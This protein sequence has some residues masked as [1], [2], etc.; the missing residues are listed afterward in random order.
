MRYIF[1]RLKQTTFGKKYLTD[2]ALISFLKRV[3]HVLE[4]VRN[5]IRSKLPIKEHYDKLLSLFEGYLTQEPEIAVLDGGTVDVIVPIYNGY[6]YLLRLFEDLPKTA[7]SCRYI[8]VDDKSPDA[9]VQELEQAFV[10]QYPGSV[11]LQN[12]QNLG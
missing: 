6:E 9:R 11:L 12:S 1:E 2:G 4:R 3:K 5:K 10:K 8:L 7:L